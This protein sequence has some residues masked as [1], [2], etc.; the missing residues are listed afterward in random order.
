M[1]HKSILL[2]SKYDRLENY[3]FLAAEVQADLV[4][5]ASNI[6]VLMSAAN[7]ALFNQQ[8]N[9]STYFQKHS[10]QVYSNSQKLFTFLSNGKVI[11]KKKIWGTSKMYR[12]T[13]IF[14]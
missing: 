4:Q 10:R 7:I 8:L 11:C 2:T 12:L 13:I 6:K 3:S 14:F 9:Y 5:C 1:K